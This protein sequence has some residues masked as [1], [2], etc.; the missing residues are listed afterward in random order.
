MEETSLKKKITFELLEE[1]VVDTTDGHVNVT[2]EVRNRLCESVSKQIKNNVEINGSVIP[3]YIIVRIDP[4]NN[5]LKM[6]VAQNI[7]DIPDINN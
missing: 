4:V 3:G 6:Y 2:D 7:E 1:I 5:S